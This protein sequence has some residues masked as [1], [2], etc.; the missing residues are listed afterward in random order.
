M[1]RSVCVCVIFSL[2]VVSVSCVSRFVMA[3]SLFKHYIFYIIMTL[4]SNNSIPSESK[5]YNWGFYSNVL[6]K[7]NSDVPVSH[8]QRGFW[9]Q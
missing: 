9:L 6:G 3:L 8:L 2:L 5:Y 7:P 4:C 1:C